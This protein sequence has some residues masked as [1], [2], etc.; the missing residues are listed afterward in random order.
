MT[1]QQLR[2]LADR[3]D[4]TKQYNSGRGYVAVRIGKHP[5]GREY[6]EYEQPSVYA[7]C[8]SRRYRYD[9]HK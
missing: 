9:T 2:E 5:N 4:R 3:I 8:N 6:I 7:E 1:A